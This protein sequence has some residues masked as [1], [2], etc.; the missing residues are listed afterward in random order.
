V[1]KAKAATKA[2][3][4]KKVESHWSGPGQDGKPTEEPPKGAGRPGHLPKEK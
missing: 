4:K 2:A 3:P 1:A